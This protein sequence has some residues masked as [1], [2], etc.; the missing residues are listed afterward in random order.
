[1]YISHVNTA[2]K[3][4]LFT[5]GFSQLSIFT[6]DYLRHPIQMA[7][8]ETKWELRTLIVMNSWYLVPHL[9]FDR[10]KILTRFRNAVMYL[11]AKR[12]L[13]GAKRWFSY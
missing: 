5:A 10:R 8:I 9:P 7:G 6:A 3:D 1:M 12:C 13:S 4:R 2:A 11:I